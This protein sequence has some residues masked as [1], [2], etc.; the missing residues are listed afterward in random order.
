MVHGRSR[1]KFKSESRYS[2]QLSVAIVNVIFYALT[3]LGET[4]WIVKF[5]IKFS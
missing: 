5:V 1:L 2:A 3:V 4:S